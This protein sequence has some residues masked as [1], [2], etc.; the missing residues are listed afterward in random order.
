MLKLWQVDASGE[1]RSVPLDNV[2]DDV[3]RN[4]L[5]AEIGLAD[6]RRGEDVIFSEART[7]GARGILVVRRNYGWDESARRYT[8]RG[9]VRTRE[10]AIK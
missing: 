1:L 8:L 2:L 9:I 7:R 4:A 3:P 6:Y 10:N 5:H